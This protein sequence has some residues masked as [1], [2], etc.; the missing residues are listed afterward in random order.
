VITLFEP[1]CTKSE[2]AQFNAALL[3]SAS[4]LSKNKKVVFFGDS[5]HLAHVAECA[6]SPI[7]HTT[8]FRSVGIAERHLRG[9][10]PRL[11]IEL[12]LIKRVWKETRELQSQML[13]ITGVTEAGLLAIKLL[14]FFHPP[15]IPILVIFHSILGQFLY[16][17]KR[18]FFLNAALS[19]KI[20]YIVLGNHIVSEL[21]NV[22]PKIQKNFSVITHPYIFEET[23]L[24]MSFI[25]KH[26]KF[27][28]VGLASKSKGFIEF[29]SLIQ[30]LHSNYEAHS[31]KKFYFIGS[32]SRECAEA[33]CDFKL[34]D[35]SASLWYPACEGKLPLDEYRKR[36]SEVDYLLM[37]YDQ[38]AYKLFFSGSSLDALVLLK[39]IVALRSSF[40]EAFFAIVGDIGYLCDDLDEMADLIS[41]LSNTPQP[42][43]Y[44]HQVL[45]LIKGRAFFDPIVTARDIENVIGNE[46]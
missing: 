7:A 6:P 45:N 8:E 38:D 27:A 11:R 39:P 24:N 14:F 10:F 13:I 43:R 41:E 19:K 29:L 21:L 28:F 17:A 46:G 25:S 20:S 34:T 37:P 4:I 18:R 23:A 2:H 36:I 26:P 15:K 3:V 22:S 35:F 9:L 31:S 32:V 16:S 44:E 5:S 1:V 30:R 42:E 33:F 12:P 40:F